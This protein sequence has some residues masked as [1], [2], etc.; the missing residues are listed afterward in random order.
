MDDFTITRDRDDIDMEESDVDKLK[1]S[2]TKRKG[3]G[4]F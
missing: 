2:V 3:R 4:K 1:K